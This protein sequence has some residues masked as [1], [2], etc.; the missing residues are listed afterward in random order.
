MLQTER[1][2]EIF[3]LL[4]ENQSITV[5]QLCEE[6]QVSDMT[7]RRD[8]RDM[9][10][11]GLLRRVHGGATKIIRHSYEPPY[12]LR[13][14]ESVDIKRQIGRKA[15]E[16]ITNGDS[17]AFDVGT[18]TLEVARALD[19]QRELT[20]VTSSLPIINELVSR[21]S[22]VTDIRLFVTGG[23]IRARELSMVGHHAT[24]LYDELHVD[25]A[26]VGVAGISIE[27]GLTEYNL[28]DALVKRAM[29]ATADQVIVVADSTKLNRITFATIVALSE[30]DMIVTDENADSQTVDRLLDQGI[31]V[32][33]AD[34]A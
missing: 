8:L 30:V 12:S 15:A 3:R 9:E 31:E 22:I 17:I 13:E 25:K 20:I 2:A 23:I 1:Q 19:G 11:K 21:R 6:F 14:T 29:I 4:D 32:I 16:L 24:R 34:S 33:L 28:D 5:A 26:F 27:Q 7:I 18:T 10:I